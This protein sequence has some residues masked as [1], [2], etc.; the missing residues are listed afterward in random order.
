MALILTFVNKSGLAPVSDYIVQ[1]L[2]GD[3]STERSQVIAEGTVHNHTR[4]DG[5]IALVRAWLDV[6]EK[7]RAEN[8]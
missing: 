2:V 7:S 5:W 3:G 1:V 8:D 4:N 6:V